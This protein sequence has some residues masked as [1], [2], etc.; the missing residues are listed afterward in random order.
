LIRS[1]GSISG[2]L[3]SFGTPALLKLF[4]G[5][6]MAALIH[7][8]KDRIQHI[9][10]RDYRGASFNHDDGVFAA[11]HYD[12]HVAQFKFLGGG[13]ADEFASPCP[14]SLRQQDPERVYRNFN[15]ADVYYRKN[16]RSLSLSADTTVA[17]I[18][19]R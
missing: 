3:T 14:L 16:S 5:G 7:E 4:L 17:M 11:S 6:R 19:D 8:R 18:C 10:F 2:A 15:A 13:V 12:F 1:T 9:L